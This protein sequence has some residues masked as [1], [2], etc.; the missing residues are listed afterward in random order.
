M[1][2]TTP[3]LGALFLVLFGLFY[4]LGIF[5]KLRAVLAFLGAVWIG[6]GGVAGR[7]LAD[8]VIFLQHV[9]GTVTAWLFG[10]AITG[11][12]FIVAVVIFIHDMHPKKGASKRT[13]WIALLLGASLATAA[14][15]FPALAPVVTAVQS[16]PQSV[17]TFLSTL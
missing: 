10:G 4:W 14:V 5:A 8:I 7:L 2:L 13:G 9:G 6:S 3:E 12:L 16:I 17:T 1:H 11:I 15:T